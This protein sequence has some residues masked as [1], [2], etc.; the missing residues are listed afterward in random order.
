MFRTLPIPEDFGDFQQYYGCLIRGSKFDIKPL[1]KIA[2]FK[3][4]DYWAV[5]VERF[6]D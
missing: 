4:T 3:S 5:D 1:L 2:G 6:P